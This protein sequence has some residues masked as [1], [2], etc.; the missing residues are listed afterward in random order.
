MGVGEE[1][2]TNG[3]MDSK[4]MVVRGLICENVIFLKKPEGDERVNLV[5]I[6]RRIFLGEGTERA[7]VSQ[8]IV[9][10]TRTSK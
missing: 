4:G 3:K 5:D 7:K 1:D 2:H 9:S 6:W 8:F 10:P